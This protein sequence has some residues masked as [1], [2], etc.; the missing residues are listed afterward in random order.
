MKNYRQIAQETLE[1][2]NS[3]EYFF[4]DK[5]IV[6]SDDPQSL[7]EVVIYTPEKVTEALMELEK[8]VRQSSGE[9]KVDFLDTLTS[10]RVNG[11]GKTLAL[12]FANAFC[13]GGG[14]LHGA[15]A[16]EEAICRSSSLY[17]SIASEKAKV[18]YDYNRAHVTPE[19]SD[20]MLLSPNVSVFRN[21][22][23]ELLNE[24]Y[25]VSVI[26]VAAPNLYDEAYELEEPKLGE[27]M[28]R[29]IKNIIAVA[30]Q[31]SFD[32]LILGAWGCGAFGHN[33]RDMA[34][35]FYDVLVNE[36]YRRFFDKIVFSVFSRDEYDYNYAQFAKRFN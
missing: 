34:E 9:I 26:T 35:Y 36:N 16:Q 12:N 6:I 11:Y 3:N 25:G 30:A 21:R 15:I 33:A 1:I 20:F 4:S 13:P 31:N 7:Q 24:P 5:K 28:R 14:F 27:V 17:A 22:D 18:M 8:N 23:C 10:A 19:G 32:T 29:K 2:I